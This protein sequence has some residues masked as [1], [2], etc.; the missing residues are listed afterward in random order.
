[1]LANFKKSLVDMNKST[2]PLAKCR[3]HL[4]RARA[5]NDEEKI[6]RLT[7]KEQE[8]NK[9]AQKKIEVL[10][11]LAAQCDAARV[12]GDEFCV[13]IAKMVGSGL[14][15]DALASKKAVFEFNA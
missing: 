11:E 10:S 6:A 8:L 1:M 4:Q 13:P 14:L 3:S 2:P 9:K 5:S 7:A 15:N 12:D